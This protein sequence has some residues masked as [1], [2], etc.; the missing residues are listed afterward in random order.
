MLTERNDDDRGAVRKAKTKAPG[1]EMIPDRV[2][3]LVQYNGSLERGGG[4]KRFNKNLT[5][6]SRQVSSPL[7][8]G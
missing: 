6:R 4:H 2:R 8:S 5:S 1:A 3:Y 7:Y